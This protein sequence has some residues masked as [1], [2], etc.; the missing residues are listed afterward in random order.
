MAKKINE[1]FFTQPWAI[2]E[3]VLRVMSEIVERHIRGEKLSIEEVRERTKDKPATPN[4]EVIGDAALIPIYGIISKRLGWISQISSSGTSTEAVKEDFKDALADPKVKRIVLDIDSPGGSITGVP[5]LADFIFAARGKKPITAFANGQMD[6]AAYWIGSAADKVYMSTSAEVGSIGVYTV[7]EDW[8]VREHNE[9]L[10]TEIIKAGKFKAVGHPS[11]PLTEDAR[12]MIQERINERY[13]QF[14]EAI[15]RNRAMNSEQVLKA[16]DGSAF[17]SQ[18]ALALGLIDGVRTFEDLFPDADASEAKGSSQHPKASA[19][20]TPESVSI[21]TQQLNK[22]EKVELTI[23]VIKKDH[24]PIAT[25]LIEEGKAAGLKEGK[26]AG[27]VEG[28]KLGREE[29]LATERARVELI[30]A[31]APQGMQDVAIACIKEGKTIEEAKDVFLAKFKA[32]AP[33]SPGAPAAP[34][35]D[36][37]PDAGLS[38]EDR[39]KKDWETK[40]EVR[41]EYASLATY[42][43]YMRAVAKGRVKPKAKH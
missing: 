32:A 41:E 36:A 4:Y 24:A 3:D 17:L 25:A 34:E 20:G 18:K 40:K 9:G 7:I 35:N 10:K 31:A 14:V 5:E 22:E 2:K 30:L 29:A 13:E 38:L 8:S 42:T 39:C 16:A 27:L 12:T 26:D 43:G 1:L 15:Q 19:P 23:E 37:A 11:K 33:P 28:T 21:E 6:S